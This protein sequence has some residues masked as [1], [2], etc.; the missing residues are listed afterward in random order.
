M[1]DTL[2][3]LLLLTPLLVLTFGVYG[4]L[5]LPTLALKIHAA[6]MTVVLGIA[7]V[8]MLSLLVGNWRITSRAS[9]VGIL[10]LATTPVASHVIGRAA[11]QRGELGEETAP[12]T[13]DPV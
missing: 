2:A 12:A 7:S 1:G 11:W 9:L 8:A 3:D 13:E 10:L 4:L 5:R 6:G